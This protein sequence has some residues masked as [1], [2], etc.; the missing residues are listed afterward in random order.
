MRALRDGGRL[1]QERAYL[2]PL[3]DRLPA[4]PGGGRQ[5][6]GQFDGALVAVDV[7]HHPAGDE[8]LRLGERAVGDRRAPLAVVPDECA[9]RGE[10]LAVDELTGPFEAAR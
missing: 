9:L 3:V 2:E 5:L 4:R 8:V 6:P 10:G 1:G 7:D